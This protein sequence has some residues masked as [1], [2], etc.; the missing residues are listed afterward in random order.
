[1]P[2]ILKVF[3]NQVLN[4]NLDVFETEEYQ[5]MLRRHLEEKFAMSVGERACDKH[6]K[7]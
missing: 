7:R 3:A 5:K 6:S 1:M 4:S 2:S